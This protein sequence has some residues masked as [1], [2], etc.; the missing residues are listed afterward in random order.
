MS[1]DPIRIVR[2]LLYHYGRQGWWPADTR[3]EVILGAVLVQHTA[4]QNVERALARL[5]K[6]GALDPSA[7][8][9]M[10]DEPLWDLLRPAGTYRVKAR[11][12]RA[13]CAWL[14]D[15]GPLPELSHSPTDRLRANLRSVHGI[16]PET[17]DAILLY[18]F[19]RPVFV[20][21]EYARRLFER[22][23]WKDARAPYERFRRAMQASLPVDVNFLNESHALIVA[24]GKEVCRKRPACERC[25][26]LADCPTGRAARGSRQ[27]RIV[28]TP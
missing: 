25:C 12:L 5:R 18:G 16:G 23:G 20:V 27:T 19:Q 26:L 3:L 1:P 7:I 9:G 17:A 15:C 10:D 28:V 2:K 6:A 11:R 8:V 24:H 21:D 22:L 4:W 14:C 13:I